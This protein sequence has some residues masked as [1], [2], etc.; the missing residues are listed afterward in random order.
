MND[1]NLIPVER[2]AAKRRKA[3]VYL[4]VV[5]CS[6][7]IALLAGGSLAA[8][9]FC[10]GRDSALA[11]QLAAAEEQINQDNKAMLE[12]RRTLA[13]TTA[14]M[15]TTRAIHEQPDWSRLLAGMSQQ[16]GRDLVLVRW[17]LVATREDGKALTEPWTDALLAKPLLS[18]MNQHRYQLVL[19]GFGQTQESVSRLALA[20]EGIGLFEQV[21]LI[22]SC[23][24]AFLGGQAVAFTMECKF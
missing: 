14:A 18:L 21:R 6:V 7:Y 13:E 11:D 12:L 4:W 2:L 22:N 23:R 10:P 15:E 5:A 20:L 8:C 17:Q 9:V 24:Q 16:L 1:V 19:Q 3:R